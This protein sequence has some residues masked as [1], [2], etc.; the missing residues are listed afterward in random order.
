MTAKNMFQ[1][2]YSR[3]MRQR[4]DENAVS[5][6]G[7]SK[8][9]KR[10]YFLRL[11]TL[12][13][14]NWVV[15]AG[16]LAALTAFWTTQQYANDR[17]QAERDRL[18]P[19]GGFVEILVAS[20]DLFVNEKLSAETLA[21]RRLP[22]EWA[23]PNTV[24]PVD[25]ES[26][27]QLALATPLRSGHPLTL[28]HVR[29]S[30]DEQDDIRLEYG[31][32]AIAIPAD[33]VSSAGG[34]IQPGDRVD[35]WAPASLLGELTKN[36]TMVSVPADSAPAHRSA[37]LVAENVRVIATGSKT[38]RSSKN[39]TSNDSVNSYAS[40]TL[41]VPAS[42]TPA[43]LGA[44]SQGRISVALRAPPTTVRQLTGED[45]RRMQ[46][47]SD[48]QSSEPEKPL[49]PIEILLGGTEESQS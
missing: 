10:G 23:L 4:F 46:K 35:L 6:S 18:I 15:A 30:A 8:N 19:A 1:K 16:L 49:A 37:F 28:D 21:I 3:L 40:L 32:R 2:I 31:H 5:P 38:S 12:A 39:G 34:H 48:G 33:E 11:T 22:N 20:R 44:I 14:K 25:F 17:V 45:S 41:A 7:N 36:T 26:V 42:K 9:I 29:Q 47:K 13:R 27:N 24:R 43:V